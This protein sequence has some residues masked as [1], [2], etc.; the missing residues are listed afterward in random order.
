MKDCVVDTNVAIVANGRADAIGQREPSISCRLASVQ[1]LQRLL[2]SGRVVVDMD[3]E[4]QAEYR[5]YLNASG[6]P[7]VGD[8][9]YQEILKGSPK[10]IL[11]VA[12]ERRDD[13]EYVDVPQVLIDTHFDRSDRKFVAL[14]I[15]R[16]IPIA[17]AVDSDWIIHRKELEES[18]LDVINICGCDQSAWFSDRE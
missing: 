6:Q 11:R 13:G 8:R 5:T 2:K 18:G 1:F 16:S 4:V 3:G 15:N 9:F 7:G 17:N 14:A 10:K 12:L